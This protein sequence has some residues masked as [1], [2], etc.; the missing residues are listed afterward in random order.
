LKAD[1]EP[2]C[3]VEASISWTMG[4][5]NGRWAHLRGEVPINVS[6]D[7]YD[8]SKMRKQ[9]G[10]IQK[11]FG[12]TCGR[13][14]TSH[15]F[16][17]I[18]LFCR[19]SLNLKRLAK[20]LNSSGATLRDRKVTY[21]FGNSESRF[22]KRGISDHL[23]IGHIQVTRLR[24]LDS[25]FPNLKVTPR[26]RNVAPEEFRLFSYTIYSD[27]GTNFVGAANQRGG[28]DGGKD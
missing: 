8:M 18:N 16:W 13:C 15:A 26:S 21:K 17:R 6:I 23:G 14:S 4:Q 5:F 10:L 7:M 28:V 19:Q 12:A 22:R 25:E 9:Y 3:V 20:S 11:S 27:N 2:I 24:N 1:D